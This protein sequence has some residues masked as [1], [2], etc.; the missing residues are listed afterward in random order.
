MTEIQP[1]QKTL[2]DLQMQYAQLCGQAGEKQYILSVTQIDLDK[3]NRELR[4]VNNK[5]AKIR[6]ALEKKKKVENTPALVS[7]IA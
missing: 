7:E 2:Q 6:E 5:A 1:E 3:I 4:K